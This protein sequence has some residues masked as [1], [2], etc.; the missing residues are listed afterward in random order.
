MSVR[1]DMAALDASFMG[2]AA[3]S[4]DSIVAHGVKAVYPCGAAYYQAALVRARAQIADYRRRYGLG[5]S[6]P[7]RQA[8]AM[9]MSACWAAAR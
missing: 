2:L 4:P 6:D 1:E 5:T 9:A 8:R 3:A 7:E